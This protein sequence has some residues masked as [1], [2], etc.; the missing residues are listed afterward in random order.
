MKSSK[1]NPD[2]LSEPNGALLAL[3]ITGIFNLWKL[4][5]DERGTMLGFTA[6]DGRL[7]AFI[8]GTPLPA[9]P[10]VLD[11]VGHL[12]GIYTA[13]QTLAPHNPEYSA[14]WMT[15]RNRAFQN[16]TP[17]E[18]IAERGLEGLIE[19]RNYLDAALG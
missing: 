17:V 3:G 9:D 11:R 4:S 10:K 1:R 15:S 5:A 8:R 16:R 18:V 19:L 7:S 2:R 6:G 13:L 14:Q 12:T